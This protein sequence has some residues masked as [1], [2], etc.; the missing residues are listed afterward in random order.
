M[1]DSDD[2]LVRSNQSS[3]KRVMQRYLE[4]TH[5]RHCSRMRLTHF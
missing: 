2:E 4:V 3:L 5:D 1:G